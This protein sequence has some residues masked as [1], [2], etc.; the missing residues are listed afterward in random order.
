MDYRMDQT[1]EGFFKE[2]RTERHV[3][4]TAGGRL[5]RTLVSGIL[6]LDPT[7]VLWMPHSDCGALKHAHAQING[8]TI[9]P[10][11]HVTM[12]TWGILKAALKDSWSHNKD[13]VGIS[14]EDFVPRVV[15]KGVERLSKEFSGMSFEWDFVD[16][17]RLGAHDAKESVLIVAEDTRTP[18]SALV[19]HAESLLKLKRG[20]DFSMSGVKAY[21]IQVPNV[22]EV[23]HD[24][25]LAK[26]ALGIKEIVLI[27]RGDVST[28][29]APRR[30]K[31]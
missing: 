10:M 2:S 22:S 4:R 31:V 20:N 23:E 11:S 13:G 3:F 18:P 6:S 19:P 28:S 27:R 29:R 26:Q 21:T 1:I 24:K 16:V 8:Q 15:R 9:W 17:S 14:I 5:N 25:L 30:M 7:R 12:Q